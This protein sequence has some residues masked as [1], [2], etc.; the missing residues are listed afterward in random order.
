VRGQKKPESRRE[1]Y[2]SSE[3]SP[4]TSPGEVRSPHREQSVQKSHPRVKVVVG[5]SAGSREARFLSRE[6]A[7]V[8]KESESKSRRSV[9]PPPRVK[10][11]K[12]PSPEK[13]QLEWERRTPPHPVPQNRPRNRGPKAQKEGEGT[14]LPPEGQKRVLASKES[15]PQKSPCLKRVLASK[16]SLPQK[17]PCRSAHRQEQEQQGRSSSLLPHFFVRGPRR[18]RNDDDI[19][20][21]LAAT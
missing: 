4:R 20:P 12:G 3:E 17:S 15:L 9:K 10:R 5:E 6:R 18:R 19:L 1:R 13:W 16:E 14:T 7:P 2:P 11:S 21:A 8:R